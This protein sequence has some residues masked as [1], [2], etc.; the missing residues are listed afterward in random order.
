MSY[1]IRITGL[2]NA[3]RLLGTNFNGVLK[4]ATKAIALEVQGTIAPYPPAT[5]ANSP[6]NDRGRWYE[7]GYGPRW[8][9]KDGSV[10]GSKTSQMLGRSWG[11]RP[12]G[13]I[14]HLVGN[15]ATYAPYVHAKDKQARFHKVRRWVTDEAA[16]VTVIRSGVVKRIVV[17][18]I[19]GAMRRR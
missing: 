7:R 19:I 10:A 18:A 13:R 17:Q 9:R 8:Q 5:E 4:S 16:V 2:D 6:S 3:R 14:G 12:T 1:G 15:R 11:I